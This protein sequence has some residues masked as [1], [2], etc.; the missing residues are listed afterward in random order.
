[1]AL[2]TF[3][4][5]RGSFTFGGLTFIRGETRPVPDTAVTAL[6]EHPW[7]DV[8]GEAA[9]EPK[10]RGRPRKVTNENAG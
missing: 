9:P 8:A 6:R 1:M 3:T 7:F 5:P 4:G 10:R 2:A